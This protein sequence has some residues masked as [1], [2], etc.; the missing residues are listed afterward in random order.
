MSENENLL[1][2]NPAV[3]SLHISN[4]IKACL[5]V[6]VKEYG[7]IDVNEAIAANMNTPVR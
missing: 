3:K 2:K 7:V 4:Y 1:K 6:Y 5:N